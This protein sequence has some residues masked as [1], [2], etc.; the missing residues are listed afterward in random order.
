MNSDSSSVE[1]KNWRYSYVKDIFSQQAKKIDCDS[2]C[3]KAIPPQTM[4]VWKITWSKRLVSMSKSPRILSE[5]IWVLSESYTTHPI[6]ELKIE[7]A[8]KKKSSYLRFSGVKLHADQRI[9]HWIQRFKLKLQLTGIRDFRSRKNRGIHNFTK[10]YWFAKTLFESF[11]P[12]KKKTRK[13][14]CC[15]RCPWAPAPYLLTSRSKSSP[16]PQWLDLGNR[17]QHFSG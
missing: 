10:S 15:F 3:L 13:T 17:G 12:L 1:R 2:Y 14:A 16:S 8:E 11:C 5:S 4:A 7:I 9:I 6:C